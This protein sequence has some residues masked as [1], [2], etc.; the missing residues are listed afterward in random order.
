MCHKCVCAWIVCLFVHVF[1]CKINL[2]VYGVCLCVG[3]WFVYGVGE[4]ASVCA[5]FIHVSVVYVCERDYEACVWSVC[6][7]LCL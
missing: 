4:C 1:L 5:Y 3:M 2:Y 7:C 6:A